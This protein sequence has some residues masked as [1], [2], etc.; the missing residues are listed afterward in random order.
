[1][2]AL[3]PGWFGLLL[4][5]ALAG[6]ADADHWPRIRAALYQD[7]PIETAN[8]TW[9]RLDTPE[10]IEDAAIVPIGMHVDFPQG[11]H[12]TVTRAWLIIDNNPSPVAAVFTFGQDSGWADIETRVRVN[13]YTE[14][15]SVVELDDGSLHMASRFV[16]ASGGCTSPAAKQAREDSPQT[17]GRMRLSV[18]GE[19]VS[20]K[21]VLAQLM[22][23]HPN[24]SGLAIDPDSHQ[25]TPAHFVRELAVTYAGAEVL[26]ADLDIAVSENPHF[27][28]YFLPHGPGELAVRAVDSRQ[29]EFRTVL[30]MDPG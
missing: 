23:S 5:S 27:R 20:G 7:R 8:V 4:W 28:F 22:I 2:R 13:A 21:P 19:V 12:R 25:A 11:A 3:A 30:R 24:D 16:M 15:R 29:L 10:R 6:A 14:V 1:M 9:L 17:L 26:K 18:P